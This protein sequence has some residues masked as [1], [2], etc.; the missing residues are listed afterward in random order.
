M[1]RGMPKFSHMLLVTVA[2]L[3]LGFAAANDEP[4]AEMSPEQLEAELQKIN[5]E[6]HMSVS[7]SADPY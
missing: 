5:E 6:V 2:L 7:P 3:A 1:A 4:D